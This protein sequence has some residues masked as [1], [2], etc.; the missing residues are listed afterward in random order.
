M[1][2]LLSFILL[3]TT[4]FVL[5]SCSLFKKDEPLPANSW[6]TIQAENI[7]QE[8]ISFEDVYNVLVQKSFDNI[9]L[10]YTNDLFE[11]KFFETKMNIKVAI[12]H[13]MWEGSLE[14][15]ITWKYGR[16][17]NN[18]PKADLSINIE[19]SVDAEQMQTK[20]SGSIKMLFKLLWTK[21]FVNLK[22]LDIQSNNP[23]ADMVKAQME[24][25]LDKWILSD[26]S[27]MQ[28]P[29]VAN[30]QDFDLKWFMELLSNLIKQN[31]V[32]KEV[33]EATEGEY[34]VYDIKLDAENIYK[35]LE[36]LV[37]SK[38]AEDMNLT[39]ADVQAQKEEMLKEIED[40]DYTAKLKVKT[41][42][43][44]SLE[45][46]LSENEESLKVVVW[47][48]ADITTVDVEANANG[49][50]FVFDISKEWTKI[51]FEGNSKDEESREL[52]KVNWSFDVI[53]NGKT[54]IINFDMN[55]EMMGAIVDLIINSE[56][57]EIDSL[58]IEE[59][60]DAQTMEEIMASSMPA[61]PEGYNSEL[62]EPAW[63]ENY[64]IESRPQE[65]ALPEDEGT[66]E[67]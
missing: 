30:L 58:D 5:A 2:K 63:F 16:E 28:M 14:A 40:L 53:K 33:G 37:T 44:I 20:W 13:M 56:N 11:N 8:D 51:A 50:V 29:E 47:I 32:I 21:T 43:D 26:S 59:P 64:E 18:I 65:I 22:D 19:W 38:Y 6:D 42:S 52:W 41:L 24:M 10:S 27:Q 36:W 3:L 60:A 12:K 34:K 31:S 49:T 4:S 55:L 7:N 35:I 66:T 61:I 62:E 25:I 48:N 45:L 17:E 57:T 1:K 46:S 9:L 39:L 15:N 67:Y 23:D 54:K